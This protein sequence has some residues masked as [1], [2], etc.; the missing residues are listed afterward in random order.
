MEEKTLRKDKI[1]LGKENPKRS[2]LHGPTQ[3]GRKKSIKI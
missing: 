3:Q 1:C 2:Y